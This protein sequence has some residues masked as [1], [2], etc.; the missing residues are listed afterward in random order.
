MPREAVEDEI[1]RFAELLVVLSPLKLAANR[2]PP[3]PGLRELDPVSPS[4]VGT[5]LA[6]VLLEPIRPLLRST[7]PVR[8]VEDKEGNKDGSEKF[9]NGPDCTPLNPTALKNEDAVSWAE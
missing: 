3:A 6:A 5:V 2:L 8:L 4:F 7:P 1:D 9:R